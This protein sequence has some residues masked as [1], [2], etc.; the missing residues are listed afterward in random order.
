MSDELQETKETV[1][2]VIDFKG[3]VDYEKKFKGYG[4]FKLTL[5]TPLR[6]IEIVR[7]MTQDLGNAAKMMDELDYNYIKNL[8]ELN[9]IVVL[10]ELFPYPNLLECRDEDLLVNLMVWYKN[11][12]EA[13]YFEEVKKKKGK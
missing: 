13:K 8:Y 3:I 2:D 7:K 10:P 11:E 9:D 6:K 5:P 12:C 1:E 4:V